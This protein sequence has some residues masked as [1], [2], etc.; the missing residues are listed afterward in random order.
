VDIITAWPGLGRLMYEALVS[1]DLYLVAGCAA[2]GAAFVAAATLA[3]D[4]VAAWN[5]PRLREHASA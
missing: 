1:R 4:L 5:D 2:V 3:A